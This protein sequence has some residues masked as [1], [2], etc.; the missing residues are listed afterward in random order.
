MT[1]KEDDIK[2]LAIEK[3]EVKAKLKNQ[4][5]YRAKLKRILKNKEPTKK[6][7]KKRV[8]K[9]KRKLVLAGDCSRRYE[10]LSIKLGKARAEY[11]SIVKSCALIMDEY[12][13]CWEPINDL[14]RDYRT[15]KDEL[16]AEIL[17]AE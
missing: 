3:Y 17:K 2:Y 10:K 8:K 6:I 14:R 4:I 7:A 1:I 13:E 5:D 9:L 15:V 11:N 12:E 16:N